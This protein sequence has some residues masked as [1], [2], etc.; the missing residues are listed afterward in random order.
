MT[1]GCLDDV[2]EKRQFRLEYVD[3]RTVG[4]DNNLF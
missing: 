1:M 4:W 3:G 2:G